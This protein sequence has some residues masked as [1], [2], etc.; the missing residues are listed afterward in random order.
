MIFGATLRAFAIKWTQKEVTA[1]LKYLCLLCVGLLISSCHRLSSAETGTEGKDQM[2]L[3]VTTTAF[4]EGNPIPRD[5]TGDGKNISPPLHWSG[6][7]EHTQSYALI[8]SDPDAPSGVWIHWVIFN[9]PA[10]ATGLKEGVAKKA[11][12]PDGAAQGINSGHAI[13][14]DG[15]APP[16]G[17]AHRYYFHVYALDSKLALNGKVTK[18]A[19]IKVMEGHILGEGQVMGKYGRG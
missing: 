17:P 15:P 3:T 19:L 13:G 5:Y 2:K 9:I 4:K 16:P 14:Y 10:D 18:D 8:C 12:L 7:P 1:M 11:L 6:A